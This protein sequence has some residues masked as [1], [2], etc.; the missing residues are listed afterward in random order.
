[1]LVGSKPTQPDAGISASPRRGWRRGGAV[2]VFAAAI[3]IAGNI[4]GGMPTWRRA[5]MVW[6]EVLT[7]A[8]R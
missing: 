3:E 5:I 7:D 8:L 4:A 6:G 2:V 1:L